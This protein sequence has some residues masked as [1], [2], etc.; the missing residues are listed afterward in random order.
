MS[1]LQFQQDG[2]EKAY[3]SLFVENNNRY[4]LAD[5]VGLGKTITAATVIAKK[6]L[7]AKKEGQKNIHIGYICGNMALALQ[8]IKKLRRKI[9]EVLEESGER[10]AFSIEDKQAESLSLSFLN[11]ASPEEES[12]AV[13]IFISVLTPAKTICVTSPGTAMEWAYAYWLLTGENGDKIIE[14]TC[15]TKNNRTE[16][17]SFEKE[18]AKAQKRLNKLIE[19][20]K[21]NYV[22]FKAE[23]N[24]LL[25]EE[26]K[27]NSEKIISNCIKKSISQFYYKRWEDFCRAGYVFKKICEM[28]KTYPFNSDKIDAKYIHQQI[29]EQLKDDEVQVEAV[30]EKINVM[31]S[32]GT[33]YD[34]ELEY[35]RNTI[36]EN[37]KGSKRSRESYIRFIWELL[38][39]EDRKK[40]LARLYYHILKENK[41][42]IGECTKNILSAVINMCQGKNTELKEGNKIEVVEDIQALTEKEKSIK[43]DVEKVFRETCIKEYFKLAR[44]CMAVASVTQMKMDLF[45]ADE[46]QNYSDLFNT[47]ISKSE[48]GL[49]VNRIIQ[50]DQKILMMSATPFRYHSKMNSYENTNKDKDADDYNEEEIYNAA[51]YVK[52]MWSEETDDTM[53]HY[54]AS[55]TDIYK[56]FL[57]IMG[58]LNERPDFRDWVKSWEDQNQKKC[59]AIKEGKK[60]DYKASI[61]AQ[62]DMLKKCNISRVERYMSGEDI[63]FANENIEVFRD[64]KIPFQILQ[65]ELQ[66]VPRSTIEYIAWE[67]VKGNLTN[68]DYLICE[69]E[70]G[71]NCRF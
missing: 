37:Y 33:C 21:E 11:Y 29:S 15:N 10:E 69:E 56:E 25:E 3:Q 31:E 13:K 18:K 19:E 40:F 5:E 14:D 45:I 6:A 36:K 59:I 54:L 35:Y 52:G 1:K 66:L 17:L 42:R 7:A 53:Q 41:D 48:M 63:R 67:D 55:E 16:N 24:K 61:K 32:D 46:I 8:N 68:G 4:L 30:K 44:K 34:Q 43:S 12:S 51:A 62:T 49:V 70:A 47:R 22:G 20:N 58:Y 23:F 9:L 65:K 57:M 71:W 2:A 38:Q 26:W 60:E 27:A 28:D 39:N 64:N 50:G